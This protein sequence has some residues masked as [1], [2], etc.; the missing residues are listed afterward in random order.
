M[1]KRDLGYIAWKDPNAWMETMK[2]TRW[3]THLSKE[4]RYFQL[5]LKDA[6]K[7][8]NALETTME[9]FRTANNERN[10]NYNWT[11]E[12]G[13]TRVCI[14]PQPG[15]VVQWRWEQEAASSIKPGERIVGDFDIRTDSLIAFTR[16][17]TSGSQAYQLV[18]QK[19]KKQL[20][21]YAGAH[22]LAPDVAIL[23]H[24][25]YV[26][27][28]ESPLRYTRLVQLDLATG[29]LRKILYEEFDRRSQ[30][31]LIKGEGK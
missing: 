20:W 30:L 3:T 11:A 21:T 4:A 6:A 16:D 28:A 13:T 17:Y 19:R 5:H 26:L 25:I 31:S 2:G 10:A 9:S 23:G 12:E 29:K 24:H 18:V 14:I 27:E 22:G 1:E 7:E 8:A 15:G